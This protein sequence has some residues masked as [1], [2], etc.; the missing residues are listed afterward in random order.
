[1]S[2]DQISESGCA[3]C[4][5]LTLVK[6]LIMLSETHVDLNILVNPGIT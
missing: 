2:P 5:Q 4:G 3:V 6:D 1:M